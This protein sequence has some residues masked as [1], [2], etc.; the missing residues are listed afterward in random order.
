MTLD[1]SVH[2]FRLHLMARAPAVG[3]VAQ[4]CRDAGIS[5]GLFYHWRKRV[6]FRLDGGKRAPTGEAAMPRGLSTMTMAIA[7]LHVSLPLELSSLALGC[8]PHGD[9]VGCSGSEGPRLTRQRYHGL[10]R[11]NQRSVMETR[12]SQL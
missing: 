5:R 9:S 3:N 1:D 10:S 6:R 4:G 7:A 2:A 12:R 11:E 8:G